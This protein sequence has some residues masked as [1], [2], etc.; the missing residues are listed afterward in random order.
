MSF[1]TILKFLKNLLRCVKQGLGVVCNKEGG[2]SQEDFVVEFL[3]EVMMHALD[4][5][6]IFVL[7]S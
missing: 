4:L 6:A 5:D 1:L 2:F 3:G 7:S